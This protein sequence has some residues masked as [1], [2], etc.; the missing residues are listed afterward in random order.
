MIRWFCIAALFLSTQVSFAQTWER[1]LEKAFADSKN[2]R[3]E[4][5]FV[6]TVRDHCE[7]CDL[8]EQ[9]VF[10][11]E[12]FREEVAS[13]YILF[14]YDFETDKHSISEQELAARLRMVEKYNKDG[15]FPYLVLVAPDG[16][17]LKSRGS[18]DGESA[19]SFLKFLK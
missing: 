16:R 19:A 6:F 11:S 12:Y 7:T 15:F 10:Q 14:K 5:L 18:Y 3:K 17:I 2:Q 9:R 4:I 1:N 8:L 13:R